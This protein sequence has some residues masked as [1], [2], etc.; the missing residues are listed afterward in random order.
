[1]FQNSETPCSGKPLRALT[2]TLFGKPYKGSRLTTVPYSNN[3]KDWAIRS[4][5]SK[6]DMTGYERPST[7]ERVLVDDEDLVNLSL[8]K[9]QSAPLGNLGDQAFDGDKAFCLKQQAAFIVSRYTIKG[10]RCK[11]TQDI[12]C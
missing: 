11:S 1:M 12:T 2:T 6:S 5:L 3:V 9:I 8:L 10:K 4:V 7:T